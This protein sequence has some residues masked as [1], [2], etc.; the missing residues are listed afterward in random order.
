MLSSIPGLKRT[1]YLSTLIFA[2]CMHFQETGVS[3]KTERWS[4]AVC[5]WERC[6]VV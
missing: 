5:C 1:P 3:E 4:T 2:C 6:I